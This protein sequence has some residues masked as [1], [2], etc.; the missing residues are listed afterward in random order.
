MDAIICWPLMLLLTVSSGGAKLAMPIVRAPPPPLPGRPTVEASRRS[1]RTSPHGH[2]RQECGMLAAA[3]TRCL[4]T[5]LIPCAVSVVPIIASST[6][7]TR[8]EH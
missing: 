6:A 2:F 7:V 4:V 1:V 8:V 5:G 3:S